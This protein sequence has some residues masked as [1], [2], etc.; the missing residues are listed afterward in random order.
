MTRALISNSRRAASA[1]AAPRG[2][3]AGFTLL[4]AVVAISILSI[5]LLGVAGAISYSV[6]TNLRS[7]NITSAKQ[8]IQSSLEQVTI[9]RDTGRLTF[10]EIGNG[11]VGNFSGFVSTYAPVTNDAGADGV[12]GTADDVAVDSDPTN[13]GYERRIIVTELNPNLKKVAVT[14]KYPTG[15]AAQTLTGIGY[16]NNDARSNFRR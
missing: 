11:A 9:L 15:R 6:T 1:P 7:K 5:G 3:Q 4:E 16:V 12:S 8:T 14:I 10:D 2:A 13:D